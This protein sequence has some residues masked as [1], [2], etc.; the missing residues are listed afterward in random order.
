MATSVDTKLLS[1]G[2]NKDN[3]VSGSDSDVDGEGEIPSSV[4]RP[5]ADGLPQTG[6]KGV[7]TDYYR[8]QQN[9]RRRAL[10]EEK[11]RRELIAKHTATVK[12]YSDEQSEKQSEAQD[13]DTTAIVNL[14]KALEEG[15]L[16]QD[17]FIKEYRAKRLEEMKQQAKMGAKRQR[18][19]NL[20][21]VR[22]DKYATVID[23]APK[24]IFVVIHIY[25]EM[26][27]G[28][29]HMN[30]CLTKLAK[31]YPTAK[32]CRVQSFQVGVSESFVKNGLP[33]LLVYKGGEMMGNLVRVTDSLGEDYN[34][35]DLE[36]FLQE[37]QCL[38]PESE[39]EELS[40][41]QGSASAKKILGT[42]DA[43]SE[44]SD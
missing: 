28:C 13:V 16:D 20:V 21:E 24:D 31:L 30:K 44:D 4:V 23:G 38:P 34:V 7:L 19:G 11:K 37:K 40:M 8:T 25:D 26:I 17:P 29:Q 14:A 32:F 3:Y 15:A 33:A 18:F 35:N 1:G 12:S 5:S 9:Q 42:Q 41:F 6:P 27:P 2:G 39:K 36:G 43:Q 10:L 22:G